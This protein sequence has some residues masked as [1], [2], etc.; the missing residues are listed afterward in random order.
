MSGA[1]AN[2]AEV[3]RHLGDLGRDLSSVVR[4]LKDA[5]E[6]ATR[7]RLA[8]DLAFSQAFLTAEGSVDLRKHQSSV[9]THGLREAAEVADAVVRHL[10]RRLNE[11]DSRIEIGRSYGAAIR[12]EL[13]TIVGG[14]Q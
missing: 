5:D 9:N 13:S 11:I 1:P 6:K 12:A 4:E 10:R 7:A 2:A 8:Y 14:A 3:A